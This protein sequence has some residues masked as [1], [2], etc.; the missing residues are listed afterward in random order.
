MRRGKKG[1]AK[2]GT[3]G[4]KSEGLEKTKRPV[5]WIGKMGF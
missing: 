3:A 4:A 1:E 5:T 2:S